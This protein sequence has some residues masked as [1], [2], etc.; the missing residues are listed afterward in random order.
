M[1]TLFDLE[2]SYDLHIDQID[3]ELVLKMKVY[4]SASDQQEKEMITK[5]ELS[6]LS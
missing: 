5:T 2:E 1:H 4:L 3:G 6:D